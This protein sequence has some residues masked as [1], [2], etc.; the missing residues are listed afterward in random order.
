MK[1]RLNTSNPGKLEEFQR[2]FRKYGSTVEASSADLREIVADHVSVVVHKASQ[3]EEG[4]LVDDTSL[5]V[6]GGGI[7][8]NIRW[9]LNYLDQ[10]VGKRAVA[11]VLLAYR[12]GE[13]VYVY[14]GE[15]YGS[16]AWPDAI[17]G[18]GFDPYFLPAGTDKTLAEE[19]PD[20]FNPRALAIQALV[21]NELFALKSPIYNWHGEW[22]I[23]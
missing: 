4:V 23:N 3:V 10:Y 6:D 5:D 22:Q 18:F 12:K 7:G 14:K 8:V 19:K 15:L 16:I 2:L 11:T 1:Y 21:H 20:H 17:G 9:L 13:K